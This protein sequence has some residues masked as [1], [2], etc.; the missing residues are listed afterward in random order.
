MWRSAIRPT[1]RWP[2]GPHAAAVGARAPRTRTAGRARR[3]GRC[4]CTG[5]PLVARILRQ[6]CDTRVAFGLGFV[7]PEVRMRSIVL[8]AVLAALGPALSEPEMLYLEAP[9]GERY[10]RSDLQGESVLPN[11]RLLTP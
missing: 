5:S 6:E 8:A 11:G 4:R 2:T 3:R 9:A 7:V 1:A 10:A